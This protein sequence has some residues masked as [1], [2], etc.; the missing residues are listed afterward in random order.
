MNKNCLVILSGMVKK[1]KKN[2]WKT[3]GVLGEELRIVAAKYLWDKNNDIFIIAS[4]GKGQLKDIIDRPLAEVI[5]GEL[6]KLGVNSKKIIKESKSNNTHEQLV[7]LPGLIKKYKF[8]NTSLI[9]NEWHLPRIKAMVQNMVPGLK[10]LLFENKIK[11][12]PAEKVLIKANP[13]KW[14]TTIQKIRI[15]KALGI[16]KKMENKG[17]EEILKGTYKSTQ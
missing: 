6:I 16:R 4:G 12:I 1:D 3:Y 2:E 8:Y 11:L 10:N 14:E 17:I 7:K 13:T 5:R 15:S 9:S